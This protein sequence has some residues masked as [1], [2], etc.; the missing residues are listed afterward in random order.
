MGFNIVAPYMVCV[1]HKWISPSLRSVKFLQIRLQIQRY[2]RNEVQP[3]RRLKC[4]KQWICANEP[5][6]V[7]PQFPKLFKD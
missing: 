1:T 3:A 5:L 6:G 4:V 7:V 2:Y